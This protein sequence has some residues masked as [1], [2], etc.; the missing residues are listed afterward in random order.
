MRPLSR[1]AAS[2]LL[3]AAP[4]LA[5]ACRTGANS[6]PGAGS[7]SSAP[8]GR[9]AIETITYEL[10]GGFA[11]FQLRVE[12]DRAGM[13][14][15]ND[16]GRVARE[17]QLAAGEWEE[18]IR[19]VEEADLAGLK[20]SYGRSGDVADAMNEVVTM[21]SGGGTV[22]VA[23]VTDPADEPPERFRALTRRLMEFAHTLPSRLEQ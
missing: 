20:A 7:S 4:L 18:L 13:A 16:R 19:L 17:G 1:R 5:L 9:L 8:G 12:I 23:V 6:S 10:S 22:R 3:R 2:A 11:G 21:R 15:L 14:V